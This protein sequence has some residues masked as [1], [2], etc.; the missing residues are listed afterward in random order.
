VNYGVSSFPDE[1]LTFEDLLHTARDRSR[2]V[3]IPSK[4][5]ETEKQVAK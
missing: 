5:I 4:L 2:Q 1:A 3:A